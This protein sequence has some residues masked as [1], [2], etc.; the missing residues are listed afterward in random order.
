MTNVKIPDFLIDLSKQMNSD[1][2]RATAHPFWQVRCK[3]Y[4]VTEKGYS[5]H[6]WELVDDDGVFY[7]SDKQSEEVAA[8]YL[9]ENYSDWFKATCDD[10]LQCNRG[11][12]GLDSMSDF[13]LFEGFDWE[14]A[15]LPDGVKKVHVQEVEE[16]V[17]THFTQAA[18]EQ[19]IARKQHDYPK[20]YTYVA[21][22]YWSPQLRELQ[23]WIKSLTLSE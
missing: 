18:A 4:L 23:D 13:D 3:R 6:H 16:V 10:L 8:E 2:S 5:E 21:S 12:H 14:Y 11:E 7:R 9:S 20:L 19:F 1:P 17:T 15:E 22:A